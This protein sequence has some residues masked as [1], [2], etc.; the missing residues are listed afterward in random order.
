MVQGDEKR[1][2]EED[3]RIIEIFNNYKS[4][5]QSSRKNK[6][7]TLFKK[8]MAKRKFFKIKRGEYED[9]EMSYESAYVNK[10]E[11]SKVTQSNNRTSTSSSP[12]TTITN[13]LPQLIEI[14]ALNQFFLSNY[15][16]FNYN[17]DINVEMVT[18]YIKTIRVILYN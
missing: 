9:Q 14:S 11:V 12:I 18:K 8:R 17:F 3:L 4:G 6:I 7:K 15:I 5:Q 2:K 10:G 16:N 1:I 13:I